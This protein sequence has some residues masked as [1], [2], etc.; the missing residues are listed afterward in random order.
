MLK[1]KRESEVSKPVDTLWGFT[2]RASARGVEY[3]YT[4]VS[5][6]RAANPS[7]GDLFLIPSTSLLHL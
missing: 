3:T 5:A 1:R 6:V 2:T 4:V 7:E